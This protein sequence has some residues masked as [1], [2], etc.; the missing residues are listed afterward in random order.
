[1]A[2]HIIHKYFQGLRAS[3][4]L[5][6]RLD[7]IIS[8][9][10]RSNPRSWELQLSRILQVWTE[11]GSQR[12]PSL[13][14]ATQT[15]SRPRQ[16]NFRG[17]ALRLKAGSP[18]DLI[19]VNCSLQWEESLTSPPFTPEI[20]GTH[21]L[22]LK[23]YAKKTEKKLPGQCYRWGSQWE[24]E[25]AK[26]PRIQKDPSWQG[27]LSE[28]LCRDYSCIWKNEELERRKES[29][30]FFLPPHL[31]KIRQTW[32]TSDKTADWI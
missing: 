6:Q 15:R 10:L 16:S 13:L 14:R 32:P 22:S 29:S 19:R 25:A 17:W 23:T 27:V 24:W 2:G 28:L 18:S 21:R 9:H 8:F 5:C 30:F 31:H 1:M 7:Q 3:R 12:F 4:R 20:T 26:P 11:T